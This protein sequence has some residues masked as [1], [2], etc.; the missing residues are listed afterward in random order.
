[1]IVRW[2]RHDDAPGRPVS[3]DEALASYWHPVAFSA[4]LGRE[5]LGTVLLGERVVVWRDASGAAVAARDRC[6]HRGTALSLGTVDDRGCLVCPY[7]GWRFDSAGS[8][9]AVP[10]LPAG[11]PLPSRARLGTFCCE[12]RHGLVWVCI[13]TPVDEIPEAAESSDPA[14]RHVACGPYR[15]RTSP[16]RMVERFADLARPAPHLAGAPARPHELLVPPYRV[17]R[18]RGELRYSLGDEPPATGRRRPARARRAP[19]GLPLRH[20]VLTLPFSF[21]RT[22]TDRATGARRAL[23]L[24]VQPHGD[25]TCSGYCV[26]SVDADHGEDG[27]DVR[28]DED[29]LAER[30]RPLVE[31]QVPPEAPL[32]AN[33]EIHLDADRIAVAYRRALSELFEEADSRLAAGG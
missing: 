17:E 16:E 8:C 3:R 14:F 5:P 12:D 13:G 1:M 33:G 28:H 20:Y 26:Q 2:R 11:S 15:W 22:W 10:Q 4:A 31:S 24:A 7:H 30:D 6:P 19:G 21:R 18:V 25:G 32:E 23:F 27:E 9:I 29:L